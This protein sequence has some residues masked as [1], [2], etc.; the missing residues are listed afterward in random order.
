MEK[1]F[2]FNNPTYNEVEIINSRDNSNII[3]KLLPF[4]K[5][6][7][8]YTDKLEQTRLKW[9]SYKI[10][11]DFRRFIRKN[12]YYDELKYKLETDYSIKYATNDWLNIYEI[13]FRFQYLFENLNDILVIFNIDPP[14]EIIL[15]LEYFLNKQKHIDKYDWIAVQHHNEKIEDIDQY[16]LYKKYAYK[17]ITSDTCFGNLTDEIKS[18]SHISCSSSEISSRKSSRYVACKIKNIK[19]KMN[20]NC[21]LFISSINLSNDNIIDDYIQYITALSLIKNNG[22]IIVKSNNI[23]IPFKIWMISIISRYFEKLIIIKP[24]SSIP[25]NS[26]VYLVGINFEGISKN[27]MDKLYHVLSTY[28]KS[29]IYKNLSEVYVDTIQIIYKM[30]IELINKEIVVQKNSMEIYE[31]IDNLES[32]YSRLEN[33]TSNIILKYILDFEITR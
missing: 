16:N 14:G 31:K 19:Q 6:I 25:Y 11:K 24:E 8:E 17:W 15:A 22:I 28:K 27:D 33:K 26:D 20:K 7:D 10:N 13:L 9:E 29:Y 3:S 5:K 21:N 12:H 32:Y 18:N 23:H 1:Y 30:L 4:R 2:S